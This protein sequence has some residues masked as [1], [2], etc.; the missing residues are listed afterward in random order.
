[1]LYHLICDYGIGDGA[2]AEVIQRFHQFDPAGHFQP[3]SVPAFAT[4]TTGF[5]IVQ[6]AIW[7]LTQNVTIF[8]NT[9]P[10][11]DDHNGRE[12]NA[13]EKFVIA[14]L[15]NGTKIGAVFAGYTFSF[16]KPYIKSIHEAQTPDRG[17]QFR[18]RDY[19]PEAFYKTIT[20]QLQPGPSIKL[21]DIPDAPANQIAYIDGYG[22]IKTTITSSQTRFTAGQNI[23]LT[24]NSQTHTAT[25]T[26]GIFHVNSG[27]LTLAPGSSGN[28]QDP[29][30]EIVLR[31]GTLT[32][33]SASNIFN[34]P[35]VES[36]ISIQT[37]S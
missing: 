3:L 12:A 2:F 11:H 23:S 25:Y 30:L 20:G 13:G 24:I 36:T 26:D 15:T 6:L 29:F 34:N 16:I 33:P 19:F 35:T 14:E 9:A 17:S 32:D 8:S 10:R 31:R 37:N 4:V 21:S 1:M 5:W 22:N 18:S 7:N 28:P 27:D